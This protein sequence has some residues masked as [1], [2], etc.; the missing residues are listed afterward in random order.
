MFNWFVFGGFGLIISTWIR[1]FNVG[2]GRFGWIRFYLHPSEFIFGCSIFDVGLV[3]RLR[4]SLLRDT[5]FFPLT[6]ERFPKDLEDRVRQD[7][8]VV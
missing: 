8:F 7:E 1:S 5:V 3:R 6:V 2:F 4:R